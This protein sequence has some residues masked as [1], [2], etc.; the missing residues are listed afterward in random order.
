MEILHYLLVILLGVLASAFFAGAETGL[1]S[2]NRVRLR[3]EVERK[4]RRAIILNGF[5]ENSE[6]LL[7]TTL[8]GTNLANV[9]VGVYVSVLAVRLC[10][11]QRF[12]VQFVAA[13]VAS[14]LLLVFGE[15]VPKT[16]FRHY[17]HR[18]CMTIAD[19][20]N[21]LAWLCAP[22]VSFVGFFMHVF[23]RLSG[24][25]EAPK[26]FFVTRE[27]LKHLA[28]EGEVGGALTVE[29]RQMIDGV[30]DFPYKTVYDVMVP[31]PRTITVP[32]DLPVAELF[33]LSQRTGFARFPVRDGEKIIGVVNVYEI[34]FENAGGAG[35]TAEQLMQ[36]PQFM[37][38]TERVN[39]VL[40]VLRASRHPISIV[41]S[42]EGKHVGIVT[43][44]D[45][46]EEIVGDVEG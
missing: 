6:R 26:S 13:V 37:A 45:I 38:S 23:V 5:V 43:I 30:F 10:H 24:G 41:V 31:M 3:H 1:I 7:G 36:K 27:E 2:L 21:A 39:R 4:N 44:E 35:K 9:L 22:M 14:G 42:P 20:L 19:V 11:T 29:E 12:W 46:V 8:F 15:I 32:R 28:K 18:L 34:V 16:L 40:P 25:K 33:A 17:S